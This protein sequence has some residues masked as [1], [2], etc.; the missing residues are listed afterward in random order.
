MMKEELGD[1]YTK[2]DELSELKDKIDSLD[3]NEK[4]KNR[5]FKENQIQENC[6]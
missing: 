6:N 4:V 2:D 3:T 5:L 1:S